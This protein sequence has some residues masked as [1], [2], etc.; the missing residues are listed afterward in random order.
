MSRVVN[1]GQRVLIHETHKQLKFKVLEERNIFFEQKENE[2][3]EEM[4][5]DNEAKGTTPIATKTMEKL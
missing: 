5:A 3:K 1:S 2:N 4:Q